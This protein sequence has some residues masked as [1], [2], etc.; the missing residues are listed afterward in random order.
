MATAHLDCFSGIAG[1]MLLAA[2]VDAGAPLDAVRAMLARLGLP[3]T[4]A[5]D[6]VKHCGVR[7]LH[8]LVEAPANQPARHLADIL[9]LIDRAGLPDLARNR[10]IRAFTRLGEAEAAVHQMPLEKVHFHEVGALDSIT[11]ILGSALALSLLDIQHIT[12]SPVPLGSGRVKC[13]HGFMP[14]PAPATALLM[15]GLPI[16]PPPVEGE[17]T[18]PTGAAVLASWVD[19]WTS[20]P[21]IYHQVGHGAGT[22]R[23]PTHPNL[24]RV[25]L[26]TAQSGQGATDLE[27]DWIWQLETTVDDISGEVLG[28]TQALLL[29]AGA[30]DVH[31]IAAQM[32]K[33]RPGTLLVVLAPEGLEVSLAQI[34]FRETRSL[35]VRKSR[36][37]RWKLPRSAGSC[38]TPWGEVRVKWSVVPGGT[39]EPSPEFEDCQNLARRHGLPLVE[40]MRVAQAAALEQRGGK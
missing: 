9:D 26:N 24:L 36:L 23:Y 38:T 33:G 17:L 39:G 11:D 14:V 20:Q 16:A 7:A 3:V 37:E 35:G 4:V 32:K 19:A 15:R 28:Y 27:T 8:L 25:F 12:A 29:E 22:R 10:A 21:G 13:D 34:L 1:D 6:E 30:L 40:V 18:T 31:A 2:L 5:V